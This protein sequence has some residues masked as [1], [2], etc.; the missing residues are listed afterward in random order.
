MARAVPPCFSR[1]RLERSVSVNA[2]DTVGLLVSRIGIVPPTAPEGI[3]LLVMNGAR[4][5]W[6]PYPCHPEARQEVRK[7]DCLLH[8]PPTV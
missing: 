1:E 7:V 2:R 5:R 4:N 8:C 6:L 3:P